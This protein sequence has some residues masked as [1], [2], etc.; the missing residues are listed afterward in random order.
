MFVNKVDAHFGQFAT[1]FHSDTS[2]KVAVNRRLSG[3]CDN[4]Y[5]HVFKNIFSRKEVIFQSDSI[6]SSLLFKWLSVIF[7]KTEK[8]QILQVLT[9]RSLCSN[10]KNDNNESTDT[11]SLCDSLPNEKHCAK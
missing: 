11:S 2:S 4:V 10:L 3:L 9:S 1:N 7:F 5:G 8:I 6:N